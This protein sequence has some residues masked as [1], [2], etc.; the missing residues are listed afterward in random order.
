MGIETSN[1]K[2]GGTGNL[3]KSFSPGNHVCKINNIALRK[4]GYLKAGESAY[5]VVLDLETKPIGENFDGWFY[6]QKDESKG[7][8]LGQTGRIKTR[9]WPYKDGA[10]KDIKFNMVDDI[11]K[12]IK[13][14]CVEIGSDFLERTSG[15]YDTIEKVVE[16]FNNSGDF[17]DVFLKWCIGGDEEIKPDGFPQYFMYLPKY[18]KG[19]K[20]FAN[21]SDADTVLIFDKIRDVETKGKTA[22]IASFAAAPE[23]DT[24]VFSTDGEDDPFA[25]DGSDDDPFA[26]EG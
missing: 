1:V 18:V 14:I 25:V 12:V 9:K 7:K 20:L 19:N 23:D 3:P 2:V 15:K 13:Q 17:K 26:V 11:L 16:E 24:P 22:P 8:F 6:D 10:W 5:E 4:P 21:E